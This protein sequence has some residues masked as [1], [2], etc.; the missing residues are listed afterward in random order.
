MFKKKEKD[1]A[2]QRTVAEI[3]GGPGRFDRVR[4]LFYDAICR[5]FSDSTCM[6]RAVLKSCMNIQ[7]DVRETGWNFIGGGKQHHAHKTKMS[8]PAHLHRTELSV[9]FSDTP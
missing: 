4:Y 5:T 9:H 6:C 2:L 8:T 7:Q 1:E 3:V